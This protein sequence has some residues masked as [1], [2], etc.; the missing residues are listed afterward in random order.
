VGK[1]YGK[2]V[3]K[4]KRSSWEGSRKSSREW[5]VRDNDIFVVVVIKMTKKL[6][7]K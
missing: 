5:E 4:K 1:N 7:L 3:L 2:E 6:G